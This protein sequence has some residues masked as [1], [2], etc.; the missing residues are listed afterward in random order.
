M[1]SYKVLFVIDKIEFQYFEFNQLVTSF[2]LI[3]ECNRRGWDVCITTQDRLFLNNSEPE[4]FIFETKLINT[5]DGV[6]IIKEKD[7]FRS[8]LEE[9]DMIL[10]RPDP[11]VD[12]N[13]INSTYVLDLV[14]TSKTLVIN[15][16]TGIRNANE[17]LYIN[18][19]SSVIPKNI[20]TNNATLIKEFLNEYGE[21]I[22]KPLNRCF[23]KGIFYLC[24]GDKNVNTIIDTATNSGTTLV[25]V[26]EYL[27]KIKDGDK[28]IIV[29][30]GKVYEETIVKI[31]GND[32]FKFNTH[33]DEFF[34]KS[35]LT[36]EDREICDVISSKLLED[37]LFIAGLDVIDGKMIEI[38]VTSPCFFIKEMNEMYNSKIE[39]RI[40]DYLENLICCKK[41][42]PRR[43]FLKI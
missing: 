22:I 27:E 19:F 2:W 5:V 15:N 14:D 9:F 13:Y 36:D 12:L 40:V 35:E 17:K 20:T 30:G 16:P 23:S 38:N 21:I 28:R 26:Q 29:I 33:K 11:P 42:N 10:F 25:M 7:S 43:C 37:G 1:N 39:Q 6:D 18:N 41:N 3:M 4:A 24:K 32:D 31:S 8:K 34:R